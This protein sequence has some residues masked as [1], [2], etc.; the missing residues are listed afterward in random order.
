M[1]VKKATM[2]ECTLTETEFNEFIFLG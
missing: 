1:I 2:Y